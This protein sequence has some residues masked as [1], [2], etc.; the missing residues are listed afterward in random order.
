MERLV[1]LASLHQTDEPLSD[2]SDDEADDVAGS[3][4]AAGGEDGHRHAAHE[5][6]H[7]HQR[8][9]NN[10][11]RRAAAVAAAAA[12]RRNPFAAMAANEIP[13]LAEVLLNDGQADVLD[14]LEVDGDD[15]YYDEEACT[16]NDSEEEEG[17]SS[18]ILNHSAVDVKRRQVTVTQQVAVKPDAVKTQFAWQ[19]QQTTAS[20]IATPNIITLPRG[21]GAPKRA[22]ITAYS[23]N[24]S[25]TPTPSVTTAATSVTTAAAAATPQFI[26]TSTGATT[27]PTNVVPIQLATAP[28]N[29]GQPQFAT[30]APAANTQAKVSF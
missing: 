23:E 13:A 6:R 10:R 26:Y 25:P 20:A 15:E 2:S 14:A 11:R 27:V 21:G 5:G 9:A 18:G 28:T 7:S 12:A 19:G 24:P 30:F 8:R 29:G 17:D 22:C 1:P 4:T 3:S 16:D